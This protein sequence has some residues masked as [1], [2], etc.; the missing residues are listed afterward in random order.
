[1]ESFS[2]SGSSSA[3]TTSFRWTS[4]STA[5]G[6]GFWIYNLQTTGFVVN[7]SYN[8]FVNVDGTKV[9]TAFANITPIK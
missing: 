1:V 7:T 3:G 2:D 9:P 4:D 5:P 8:V 6:G